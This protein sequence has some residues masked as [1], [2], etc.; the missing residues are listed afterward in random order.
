MNEIAG[1]YHSGSAWLL[2]L[3]HL[4][5][6]IDLRPDGTISISGDGILYEGTWRWDEAE[7]IVR[8]QDPRWD[9]RIRLRN[10]LF[11]TR[12]TMRISDLTLD[13]DHPEHDE[14]VELVKD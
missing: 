9:H 1:S 10:H 3:S 11:G 7:G 6:R 12:L 8:V 2:D 13:I 5:K 4:P 14:E